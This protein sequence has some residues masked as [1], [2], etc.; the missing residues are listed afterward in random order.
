MKLSGVQHEV[1]RHA[2]AH[3]RPVVFANRQCCVLMVGPWRAC[4][5]VGPDRPHH[6]AGVR[7]AKVGQPGPRLPIYAPSDA[8]ASDAQ[9][10]HA[11]RQGDS[12]CYGKNHGFAP[13]PHLGVGFMLR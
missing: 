8:A 11:E 10:A 6:S 2:F 5:A 9:E 13:V 7:S 1:F 12:C 4:S 3:K